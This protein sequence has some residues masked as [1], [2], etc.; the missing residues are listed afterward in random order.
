MS[1]TCKMCGKDTGY[2]DSCCETLIVMGDAAY[3]PLGYRP[4]A[5]CPLLG[6]GAPR[7]P[8]CNVAAGGFHHVG[9]GMEVCPRCGGW[10]IYCKC[11]GTKMP[12]D[13]VPEETCR[14]I[15]FAPSG[16]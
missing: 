2:A 12:A 7:C 4:R 10:W 9:C 5:A 14:V 1:S 11:N 16:R 15:A 3:R 6:P 13:A 8:E